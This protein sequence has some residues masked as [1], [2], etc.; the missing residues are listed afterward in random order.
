MKNNVP[1]WRY[2]LCWDSILYNYI[3]YDSIESNNIYFVSQ[4]INIY[5]NLHDSNVNPPK[6]LI[7]S[8]LKGE[9]L[10]VVPKEEWLSNHTINW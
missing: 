7:N 1:E 2:D 6:K 8:L 3:Q 5:L 10:I 4:K 9:R